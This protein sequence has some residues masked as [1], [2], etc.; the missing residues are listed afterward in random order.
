MFIKCPQMSLL[1]AAFFIVNAKIIHIFQGVGR[2][3]QSISDCVVSLSIVNSNGDLKH[4]SLNED[5]D[6]MRAIQCSLGLWGI[7]VEI[8]MKV[9]CLYQLFVL[10][11]CIT[12]NISHDKTGTLFGINEK[13]K[14]E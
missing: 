14:I 7:V 2:D 8:T 13:L 1:N 4:Y 9:I 11:I 6:M 3:V 12:L 10:T 5:Q